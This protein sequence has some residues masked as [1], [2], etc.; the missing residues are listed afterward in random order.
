MQTC[1]YGVLY[2]ISSRQISKK[3]IFLLSMCVLLCFFLVLLGKMRFWMGF[4][5]FSLLSGHLCG[6]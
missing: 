6:F 1:R 4:L 3:V 5:L 2:E